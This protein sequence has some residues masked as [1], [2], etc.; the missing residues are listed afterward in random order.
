M[1]PNLDGLGVLRAL[2]AGTGPRVVVVSISDAD[3]ALAIEAALQLGAV[4]LVHKPTA[5]ATDRL[6]ELSGELVTKV[7]AAAAATN[8]AVG[9][10]AGADR[11]IQAQWPGSGAARRGR[12]HDRWSAGI[13]P[14]HHVAPR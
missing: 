3:S 2:P 6:Y 13:D 11:T 14:P 1:M 9:T 12:D 4:D 10:G 7:V 5:L 8:R